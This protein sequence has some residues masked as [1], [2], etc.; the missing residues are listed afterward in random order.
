[1]PPNGRPTA[2]VEPANW[3]VV[4][5]TYNRR[6]DADHKVAQI[7]SKF[8][9][10]VPEVISPKSGWYLVTLGGRMTRAQA[11]VLQRQAVS[12]G[13]PSGTYIQNY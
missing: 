13:M 4:A 2:S 1:M 5:Y 3:R 12:K 9:G 11:R 6:K 10:F 7:N 8:P